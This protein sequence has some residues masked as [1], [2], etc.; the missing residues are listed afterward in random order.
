MAVRI[1]SWAGCGRPVDRS[2]TG[3][4]PL[5]ILNVVLNTNDM[6]N[7]AARGS[8]ESL[9]DEVIEAFGAMR[10]RRIRA[11]PAGRSAMSAGHLQVLARLQMVGAM[12]VSQVASTLGVSAAAATGMVGRMEERGLVRRERDEDDRRVVLVELTPQGRAALADLGQRSR[13]SLARALSR[14]EEGELTQL[15]NGLRAF[16]RAASA[17]AEEETEGECGDAAHASQA[18]R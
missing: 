11:R 9:I 4:R 3:W 13:A 2:L 18:P 16:Q 12:P 7:D 10:A 15:R 8:K 14:M 5:P 1:R 6:R 17:Q